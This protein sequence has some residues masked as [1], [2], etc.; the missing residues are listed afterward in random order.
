MKPI[1]SFWS[2]PKKLGIENKWLNDESWYLSWILSVLSITKSYTRPILYTDDAGADL[3]VGKMGLEFAEIN[4]NLNDVKNVN[5]HFYSIGKAIAVKNQSSSFIHIDNDCYVWKKIPDEYFS[6]G[7]FYL[8]ELLSSFD[9][10]QKER[11]CILHRPDIFS[12]YIKN[13]PEWWNHHLIGNQIKAYESGIFGGSNIEFFHEWSDIV[14]EI[15]Q[16]NDA[17]IWDIID[18]ESRKDYAIEADPLTASYGYVPSYTL[19]EYLPSCLATRKSII[20]NFATNSYGM[21]FTRITHISSD[22]SKYSDLHGR[23]LSRVQKD[24]PQYLDNLYS[25]GLIKSKSAKNPTVT[26]SILPRR[27]VSVYDTVLRCVVPRKLQPDQIIVIDNGISSNDINLLSKIKEVKLISGKS[28]TS[29]DLFIRLTKEHATG[30]IIIFVDGHVRVPKLYIEKS[31][32]AYLEDS[33]A[34]YCSA[35]T[36]FDTQDFKIG[37]ISYGGRLDLRNK[38]IPIITKE[39]KIVKTTKVNAL[40]GGLYVVPK[41]ILNSLSND[42]IDFSTLSKRALERSID[43]KCIKNLIVSHGFKKPILY[44]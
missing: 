26:V 23:L 14:L 32:G 24:Y 22:K 8:R 11:Y 18:K 43:I 37:D 29:D 20:P 19:D 1:M 21:T 27:G 15:I 42:L 38:S 4:L 7:V 5:P 17:D 12:K 41:N 36:D 33:N 2:V 6:S 25:N 16:G 10:S 40:Y 30:D 13:L 28:A 35:A 9:F 3:L 44:K 34:I 39:E 31:I